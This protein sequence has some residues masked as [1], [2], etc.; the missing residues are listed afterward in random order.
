MAKREES[1]ETLLTRRVKAIYLNEWHRLGY[2]F[3]D[4]PLKNFNDGWFNDAFAAAAKEPPFNL[5]YHK[6]RLA[7]DLTL[8]Q[9][10]ERRQ[11]SRYFGI[12]QGRIRAALERL[13]RNADLTPLLDRE[14]ITRVV[15]SPPAPSAPPVKRGVPPEAAKQL[16]KIKERL[17]A[18][19]TPRP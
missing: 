15:S 11:Y 18:L 7:I 17:L 5:R 8:L 13:M 9:Q 1:F 2:R 14:Q 6:G 10:E 12:V 16:A 3:P 4:N 19:P